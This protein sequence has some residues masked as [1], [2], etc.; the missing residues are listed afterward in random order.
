[1]MKC[2]RVFPSFIVVVILS[3]LVLYM[4]DKTRGVGNVPAC[5][6]KKP[7]CERELGFKAKRVTGRRLLLVLK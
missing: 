2:L 5:P 6:G 4:P 3:Q 7:A 1:M